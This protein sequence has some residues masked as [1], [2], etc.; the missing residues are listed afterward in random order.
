MREAP[1][2]YALYE[3][4]DADGTSLGV[5]IGVLPDELRELVAYGTATDIHWSSAAESAG[6]PKQVRWELATSKQHAEQL[7]AEH[8]PAD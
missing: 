5:G 8:T 1:D 4:G 3:I 6:D 2:R 7:L